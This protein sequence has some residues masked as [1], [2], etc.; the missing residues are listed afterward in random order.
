M[1]S[2]FAPQWSHPGETIKSRFFS[3]LVVAAVVVVVAC[4]LGRAHRDER[5]EKKESLYLSRPLSLVRS[6]FRV[7][8]GAL[9]LSIGP[10]SWKR[11]KRFSEGEGRRR[12][13]KREEEGRREKKIE[14]LS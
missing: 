6:S 1:D 14:E 9:E 13:K 10:L 8:R 2:R 11:E 5:K 12:G 3:V 7:W 4:S